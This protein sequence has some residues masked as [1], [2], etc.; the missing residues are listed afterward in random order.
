M[1]HVLADFGQEFEALRK[2]RVVQRLGNIAA[3][4]QQVPK[5]PLA[6]RG[7]WLPVVDLAWRQAKREQFAFVV[8]NQVEFEA[9]KPAQ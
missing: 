4:A 5:E 3:I 7:H 8:H 1:L 2:E 9:I 6:Q